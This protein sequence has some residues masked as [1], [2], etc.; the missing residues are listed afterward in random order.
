MITTPKKATQS[1]ALERLGLLPRDARETREKYLVEGTDWW[2]DGRQ[3]FWT[4]EAIQRVE[5]VSSEDS[6][7]RDLQPAPERATEVIE[8]RVLGPCKN[9]RFLYAAVNGCR[10][11]VLMKMRNPKR[12]L[13]KTIKIEVSTENGQVTYKQNL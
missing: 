1:E 7:T 3:I 5:A 2:Q 9:K 12:M 13:G 10:V 6:S 8:A 4:L 11:P